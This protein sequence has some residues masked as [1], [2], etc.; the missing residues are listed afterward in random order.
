MHR[1]AAFRVMAVLALLVA[2][3]PFMAAVSQP[4]QVVI[5]EHEVVSTGRERR[6]RGRLEQARVTVPDAEDGHTAPSKRHRRRRD[7]GIRARRGTSG[8]YDRGP[9]NGRSFSAGRRGL[10]SA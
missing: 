8:K 1:N 2:A 3:L 4:A 5:F 10:H 7:D 6:R 9:A